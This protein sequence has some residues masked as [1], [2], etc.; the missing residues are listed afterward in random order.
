MGIGKID[1]T[2]QN[3]IEEKMPFL[4]LKNL[5][6][7]RR[8]FGAV[9]LLAL[10]TV[11]FFWQQLSGVAFTPADGGDLVSF[12]FPIYSFA[13]RVLHEGQFPLWNPHLYLGAPHVADVQAG[14]LYP[15]TLLPLLF[16]TA[17]RYQTLEFLSVFHFFWAGLGTYFLIRR[18]QSFWER[19]SRWAALAGALAFMFSDPLLTHFGNY[20][21][22]AVASWLPW[23]LWAYLPSFTWR[24]AALAG[25]LLGI[26]T[27]AGHPQTTLVIVLALAIVTALQLY[28]EFRAGALQSWQKIAAPVARCCVA[29]AVAAL[30]SAPVLLPA[31]L[32]T[33][34]TA[35]AEF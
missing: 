11:A 6:N 32:H 20:N 15:F 35:R 26:A 34:W 33:P 7:W 8:D 29:V 27:L 13:Q 21:L 18:L 3:E 28:F 24:R 16:T 17:L 23:V 19:G 12:L 9:V 1:V 30:I 4:T 5:L 31:I 2:E 25:L 22:L 14:W 10:A